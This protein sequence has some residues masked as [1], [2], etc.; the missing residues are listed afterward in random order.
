MSLVK[1]SEG[2]AED[3]QLKDYFDLLE[4]LISNQTVSSTTY[5]LK[6]VHIQNI[7]Q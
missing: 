6:L 5:Y 3:P 7:M 4:N 2:I 1:L